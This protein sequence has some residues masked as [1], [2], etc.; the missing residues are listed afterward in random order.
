YFGFE[1]DTAIEAS[2]NC[3]ISDNI[4]VGPGRDL[5]TGSGYGIAVDDGY[6]YIFGNVIFDYDVAINAQD[7]A[8]IQGN[9]FTN[10]SEAIVADRGNVVVRNNTITTGER[11]VVAYGAGS[12]TIDLNLI[13]DQTVCGV[14]V[15]CQ[16]TIRSNTIS[17]TPIALKLVNSPSGSIQY[18][19]FENYTEYSVYFETNSNNFDFSHNWWGTTDTKAINLTI[20]DF[21]YDFN[22]EK[23][24]FTPFLTEPNQKALPN[25]TPKLP[26]IF[27]IPEFSSLVILPLLFVVTFAVVFIKKNITGVKNTYDE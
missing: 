14:Y 2:G 7:G 17:N 10:N 1:Y 19:N 26:P 13:T 5:V 24:D 16:N 18:N 22:S 15:E 3:E 11:G 25:S 21:K 9:L 6:S 23:V 20:H 8:T 12:V 27:E 4:I